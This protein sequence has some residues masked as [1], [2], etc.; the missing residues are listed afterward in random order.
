MSLKSSGLLAANVFWA[1]RLGGFGSAQLSANTKIKKKDKVASLRVSPPNA[2][3]MLAVAEH[4]R[5]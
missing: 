4:R 3:P 5:R 2:K 1:L